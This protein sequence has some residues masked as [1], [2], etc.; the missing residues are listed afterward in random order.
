MDGRFV[1]LYVAHVAVEQPRCKPMYALTQ[2]PCPGGTLWPS[3]HD[4]AQPRLLVQLSLPKEMV[5]FANHRLAQ[6]P[7]KCR[8]EVAYTEDGAALH[9]NLWRD[10]GGTWVVG[11]RRKEK[12]VDREADVPAL[13]D[14]GR[15]GDEQ[16]LG[17]VDVVP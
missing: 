5:E 2:V 9:T 3:R 10:G 15:A 14:E 8:S 4:C 7:S 16:T 12:G 17:E 1:Q 11:F 13:T 6:H